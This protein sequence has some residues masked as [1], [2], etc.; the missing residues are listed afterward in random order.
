MVV[1]IILTPQ[2]TEI[3]KRISGMPVLMKRAITKE[4]NKEN[5]KTVGHIQENRLSAV[6]EGPP[7][8]VAEGILRHM[9]GFMKKTLNATPVREVMGTFFSSIGSN[10]K[11]AAR[12]E[13][14]FQG[15]ENV[16]AHM[17]MGSRKVIVF[18][19]RAKTK[20][21][22]QAA[23]VRAGFDL[24]TVKFRS[25]DLL[26]AAVR[27]QKADARV[28]AR[29]VKAQAKTAFISYL[30]SQRSQTTVRQSTGEKSIQV[31]SFD[32]DAN[33]PARAPIRRGIEDRMPEYIRAIS[34]AIVNSISPSAPLPTE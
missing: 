24:S 28:K 8:P 15:R 30:D 14:G 34:E 5:W 26:K 3:L 9:S 13:F 11:Y 19:K 17:R 29:E 27:Q 32:R 31:R 20:F 7:R 33:T 2:A 10:M 1:Q 4:L 25:K 16:K 18:G 23:P 6:K 22:Y 21:I 12:H